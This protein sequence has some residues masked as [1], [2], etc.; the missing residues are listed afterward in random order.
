M[1]GHYR[2]K[3]VNCLFSKKLYFILFCFLN[4]LLTISLNA[5]DKLVSIDFSENLKIYIRNIKLKD[6]HIINNSFLKERFGLKENKNY[7]AWDLKE[8]IETFEK[9]GYIEKD[10]LK[11]SIKI[12]EGEIK[13]DLF[14]EY[15]EMP[16]ISK[17]KITNY[18]SADADL[19]RDFLAENNIKEGD[20]ANKKNFD[21]GKNDFLIYYQK[22]GLFLIKLIAELYPVDNSNNL[23]LDIKILPIKM[24]TVG[25]IK[26]E[27][28]KNLSY[29]TILS[30]LNFTYGHEIRNNK[31]LDDSYVKIKQLGLF[32]KVF[33]KFKQEKSEEDKTT[34]VYDIIIIVEE[35]DF[36]SFAFT[37]EIKKDL[38]PVFIAQY[39]NLNV[40]GERDRILFQLAYEAD[41]SSFLFIAEYT[42]PDLFN[43]FFFSIRGEKK[44][45]ISLINSTTD[46]LDEI[47]TFR[48]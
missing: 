9:S 30:N 4:L 17:I 10:S 33:F 48:L 40:A 5:E 27:G 13:F 12:V 39:V 1:K 36:E 14:M 16:S 41:Y 6:A 3:I 43:R 22:E 26:V 7:W 35:V 38:G 24:F 42:K 44:D 21:K 8:K 19:L 2:F 29:K 15:K 45:F 28:S 20:I 47:Y 23:I 32:S 37:T 25:F 11:Y 34:D 18:S 46:K 31:I